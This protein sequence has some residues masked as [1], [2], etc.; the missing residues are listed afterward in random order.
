MLPIIAAVGVLCW[1]LSLKLLTHW[2]VYFIVT[3][4]CVRGLGDIG[5][6]LGQSTLT[7]ITAGVGVAQALSVVPWLSSLGAWRAWLPCS[8]VVEGSL[9]CKYTLQE[10]LAIRQYALL[11]LRAH[12]SRWSTICGKR[13]GVFISSFKHYCLRI[14]GLAHHMTSYGTQ[15]QAFCAC[16]VG[17]AC[18]IAALTLPPL[19]SVNWY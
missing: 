16:V 19:T 5:S 2:L 8:L 4:G 17:G 7:V 9:Q 14:A 6:K 12:F 10:H 3:H 11:A 18:V 1:Q 15:Q 13:F